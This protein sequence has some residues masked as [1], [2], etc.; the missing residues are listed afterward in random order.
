MNMMFSIECDNN[1]NIDIF[2][3]QQKKIGILMSIPSREIWSHIYSSSLAPVITED[4]TWYICLSLIWFWDSF[5]KR[6]KFGNSWQST[7]LFLPGKFH[8]QRSLLLRL[9]RVGHNWENTN[10]ISMYSPHFPPV[11]RILLIYY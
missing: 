10:T 11:L 7:P 5:G 8:G 2:Q 9:Q 3:Q 4:R 1:K 6:G